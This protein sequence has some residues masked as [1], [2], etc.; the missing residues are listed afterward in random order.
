MFATP[1]YCYAYAWG[2]LLALSLYGMYTEDESFKEKI[3]ILL[4]HGGSMSPKDMLAEIGINPSDEAFWQKGF[5]IIK[6]QIESLQ[7]LS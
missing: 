5:D 3:V 7:K 1:F 4:E 2:N 6:E